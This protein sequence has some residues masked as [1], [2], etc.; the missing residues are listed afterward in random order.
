MAET[1]PDC[2]NSDLALPGILLNARNQRTKGMPEGSRDKR[3]DDD[4]KQK[5]YKERQ[6]KI[7]KM[8]LPR[9]EQKLVDTEYTEGRCEL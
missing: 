2:L 5:R 1:K 7:Q 3:V 4:D 8:P 9:M 6:A